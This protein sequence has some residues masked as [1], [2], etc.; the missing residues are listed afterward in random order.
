MA[1]VFT[2]LSCTSTQRMDEKKEILSDTGELTRSELQKA[3]K[4]MAKSL[5]AYKESGKL[6]KEILIAL[7]PTK[8][9]TTELLPVTVFDNKMMVHW[10]SPSRST[11]AVLI[12]TFP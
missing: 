8:N 3:A 11:P 1:C 4:I 12:T 7:L 10:C 6:K 5:S 2:I 9:E